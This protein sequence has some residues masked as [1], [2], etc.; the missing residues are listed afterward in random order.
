MFDRGDKELEFLDQ[1]GHCFD[2]GIVLGLLHEVVDAEA[3]A[4]DVEE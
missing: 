2:E 4:D 1:M 3:A